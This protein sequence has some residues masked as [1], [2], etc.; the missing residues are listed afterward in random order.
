MQR[1]II[2]ISCSILFSILPFNLF[3]QHNTQVIVIPEKVKADILKRHPKAQDFQASYENHYK[4]KLLE[5][6]FKEEGSD[7]QI[8]EL[9]R[10]DGDLFTRELLL[11]DLSEAAPEVKQALQNNFPGFTLKRAEMIANPN[12]V[13]EEYE[14]YL[15]SGGANWRVSVTEKGE[16]EEKTQY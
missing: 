14:I 1:I 11:D 4:R 13:G 15:V 12:G 6:S 5:V 16:I 8:L 10:D 9:F 2:T 3:A 7:E